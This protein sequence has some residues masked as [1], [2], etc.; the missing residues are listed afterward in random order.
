LRHSYLPSN[1]E[2][3]RAALIFG[4]AF[5]TDQLD[6]LIARSTNQVTHLGKI[7][8][9]LADKVLVVTALILLIHMRLIHVWIGV[10]LCCREL[11]INAL[12]ALSQGEG[13]SLPPNWI[14]K[15]KAYFEGFGIGFVMLGPTQHYMNVQWMD[16]GMYFLYGAVITA[17]VSAF[18]YFRKYYIERAAQEDEES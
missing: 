7:M 4:L 17:L 8:D 14:G 12:R 13:I 1:A 3:F 16:L 18:Q 11:V 15:M 6:G 2:L 9:P 5:F 10:V